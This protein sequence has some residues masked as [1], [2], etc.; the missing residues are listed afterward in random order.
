MAKFK[1]GDT[2]VWHGEKYIV[3]GDNGRGMISLA[4][5]GET[6]AHIIVPDDKLVAANSARNANRVRVLKAERLVPDRL[7]GQV[8][9]VVG[10][11]GDDVFVKDPKFPRLDIPILLKKGEYEAA[12][13]A[14]HSRNA[15]VQKALNAARAANGT[16]ETESRLERE[17]A[18]KVGSD[19]DVGIYGS[20]VAIGGLPDEASAGKAKEIVE[21]LFG[22]V[23]SWQVKKDIVG[24]TAHAKVA[25]PLPNAARARNAVC[26]WSKHFQVG[27]TVEAARSAVHK[28]GVKGTVTRV[29]PGGI[30]VKWSDD[31]FEAGYG[32]D[33]NF[34]N[35]TPKPVV[36]PEQ[37]IREELGRSGYDNDRDA[38]Y[39]WLTRHRRGL[40]TKYGRD[41]YE[42]VFREKA[43]AN[44]KH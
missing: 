27:D 5:K 40:V 34:K 2:V 44:D 33:G 16:W 7:V 23:T 39:S 41:A 32:I 21:R 11:R 36:P 20:A 1:V 30:T 13:S 29:R 18:K 8:V 9:E 35:I 12:N 37:K 6:Y 25:K 22:P 19:I 4:D 17:I 31:G 38:R 15:V 14:V 28:L 3:V 42:K 10:G 24:Y 43:A 26:N